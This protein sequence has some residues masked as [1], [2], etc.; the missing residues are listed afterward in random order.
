MALTEAQRSALFQA[1]C[2]VHGPDVARSIMTVFPPTGDD[3][4]ATRRDLVESQ[5]EVRDDIAD[6][7]RDLAELRTEVRDDI[8]N[9][10]RDLAEL[11]TE[12]RGD[13]ADT[14][15][16][17][18]ELRTEVRADM[19]VMKADLLRTFGTWLFAS[20]AGVIAAVAVLVAFLG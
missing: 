17:L 11:R 4:P 8:A 5:T 3:E 18:A 12:V 6:T 2:E 19:A 10:K 20:Q 16:D 9:V 15:R 14:K 7:K 1:M 13:I